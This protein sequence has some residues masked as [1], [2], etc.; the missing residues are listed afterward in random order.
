M[1]GERPLLSAPRPCQSIISSPQSKN[2]CMHQAEYLGSRHDDLGRCH[3]AKARSEE[4]V[5]PLLLL[6]AVVKAHLRHRL[7][8]LRARPHAALPGPARAG[9]GH[10]RSSTCGRLRCPRPDL[11]GCLAHCRRRRGRRRRCGLRLAP[12]RAQCLL[13]GGRT[14]CLVKG[15]TVRTALAE[16]MAVRRVSARR[17][18]DGHRGTGL[19]RGGREAV[20]ARALR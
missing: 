16:A 12:P 18:R 5:P 14:L 11:I 8:R 20:W 15:L 3:Q 10:R 2:F 17:R 6:Q 19:R 7:A 13:E 9:R 1:A 4:S